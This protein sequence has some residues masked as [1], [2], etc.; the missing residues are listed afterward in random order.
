MKCLNENTAINASLVPSHPSSLPPSIHPSIHPQLSP[1][2]LAKN[3]PKWTTLHPLLTA[4]ALSVGPVPPRPCPCYLRPCR[5]HQ[6]CHPLPPPRPREPSARAFSPSRT[7]ATSARN[8]AAR[9]NGREGPRN[10]ART[11][12]GLACLEVSGRHHFQARGPTACK[13]APA[14][15]RRGLAC[16]N[17]NTWVVLPGGSTH[18]THLP[19]K[20]AV[21]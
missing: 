4:A 20:R 13:H 2:T 21:R 7:T 3:L 6:P 14:T 17:V 16:L 18:S 10:A 8:H 1:C 5:P 9:G 19:S 15:A 12:E 11:G